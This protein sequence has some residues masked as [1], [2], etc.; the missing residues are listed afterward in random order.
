MN[1]STY[2][3]GSIA[4]IISTDKSRNREVD[5]G[6]AILFSK[7]F[8]TSKKLDKN[9]GVLSVEKQEKSRKR[10]AQAIETEQDQVIEE[11]HDKKERKQIAG[12][13][14]KKQHISHPAL[15]RIL[16][17]RDSDQESRTLFCG[18]LP[19][20]ATRKDVKKLFRQFGDISSVRIRSA[21]SSNPKLPQKAVVIRKDFHKGKNNLN[22]YIVFHTKE[23]AEKALCMN[24][25]KYGDLH[26]RVDLAT[27]G[28]KHEQKH[29]VF[30]GNLPFDAAEDPLR[31]HFD[32]CG[33]ID[34][35][36]L[37]RDRK[38]GAGK[39]IGYVA[40]ANADGVELA[41]KLDGSKFMQRNVRV[42]RSTSVGEKMKSKFKE[43]RIKRRKAKKQDSLQQ[44]QNKRT[45]KFKNG[46]SKSAF[47]AITMESGHYQGTKAVAF[48]KIKRKKKS[49]KRLR[50]KKKKADSGQV[51][52]KHVKAKKLEATRTDSTQTPKT[53]VKSKAHKKKQ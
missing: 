45:D 26:M 14:A 46:K 31:K 15:R 11:K 12:V 38:T 10:K 2:T 1:P 48:H 35:V 30:I 23:S 34:Y 22:A 52:I 47:S 6:L 25:V 36:R 27:S 33:D 17:K 5:K 9:K 7:N 29:C 32:N 24:G 53:R 4:N 43:E 8:P 16:G 42:T 21:A 44:K 37:V 3:P 40:F 41:L 19:V 39:G 51:L 20:T 18:N 13:D 49:E 28:K 50:L